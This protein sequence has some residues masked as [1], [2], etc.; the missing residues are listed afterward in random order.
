MDID[1]E[2]ERRP[3]DADTARMI[4]RQMADA[5]QGANGVRIAVLGGLAMAAALYAPHVPRSLTL[6]HA[7]VLAPMLAWAVGQHFLVHRTRRAPEQ[8]FLANIVLDITATTC[9]LLG[10]GI[11]A[12]PNMAAKSPVFSMYFVV[13][14][15]RP[16][17]GSPRRAAFAGGLAAAQYAAHAAF[18]FVS[19]RL[20]MLYDPI[21]SSSS[22]GSSL[23]DQGTRILMLL[24]A[25][26]VSTYATRWVE[27]TLQ[28]GISA[29][30]NADARFRAVF[31]QTGVGVALLSE[32]WRVVEANG[33]LAEFLGTSTASLTGELLSGYSAGEDVGV[34]VS[35]ADEVSR[36]ERE[37]ASAEVRYQRADGQVVWGSFTLSR[38]EDSRTTRLIAVVQD[39]TQ[40]KSLEKELLRQAFY[41]QLTGLA[42]RSLFR[43]RV[44]H[45]LSRAARERELLAVM[46][47]DLD[48][49]KSINDTMGHGAGDE[50]LAIVGTRLLNAT[51]GCDTVARL[52]GDEFAVLLEHVRGEAD[53]RSSPTASCT[54]SAIRSPCRPAPRFGWARASG[55]PACRPP[56]AST[57]CCATRMSR[58]T[59]PR[60][61]R[62]ADTPSS[63]RRCM[64]PWWT[65]YRSRA[66]CAMRSTMGR[67]GSPTSR[68][69]RWSR[70]KCWGSR[71]CSGGTIPRVETWRPRS[72]STLRRRRG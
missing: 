35:M 4:G 33:A 39:V 57:N 10:Y 3:L 45:A 15:T 6:V 8:L 48:N 43:D 50:L 31:E 66:T 19:G 27:R 34:V 42:N 26:V 70:T 61:R 16:F 69:L 49:F 24:A 17:T 2:G 20:P 56:T 29:R 54:R 25:G 5:E 68:S 51:R 60:A 13:L 11:W 62:A 37:T 47:L 32:S 1:R 72:S 23:L 9:L 44:S 59:P 63:T 30:R 41:D 71:R 12:D 18:Q 22:N 53:A 21:L 52:G 7:L 46:F 64:P 58:C 14:A 65:G 28:K 55:S 36:G 67:S 40:R 38:A